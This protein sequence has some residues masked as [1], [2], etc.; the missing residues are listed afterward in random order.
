MIGICHAALVCL[1]LWTHLGGRV[2]FL[3][4]VPYPLKEQI[5]LTPGGQVLSASQSRVG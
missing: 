2:S 5:L 1:R 3:R 4:G